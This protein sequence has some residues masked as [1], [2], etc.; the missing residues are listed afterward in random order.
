[1]LIFA[2]SAEKLHIFFPVALKE[3]CFKIYSKKFKK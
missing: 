3:S 1:M 2:M